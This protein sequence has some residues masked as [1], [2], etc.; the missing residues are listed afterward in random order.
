M[1]GGQEADGWVAYGNAANKYWASTDS[2][3]RFVKFW[4]NK[5]GKTKQWNIHEYSGDTPP[6][7]LFNAPANC[8][9][10]CPSLYSYGCQ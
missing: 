10:R 7:D 6:A 4:D 5:N 9:K 3:Q 1:E 8:D 2:E